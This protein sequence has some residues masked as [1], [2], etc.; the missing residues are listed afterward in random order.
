MTGTTAMICND[1]GEAIGDYVDGALQDAGARAALERHLGDCA[2]CRALAADLRRLRQ[3]A[4][5]LDVHPPPP[6]AW[7][8]IARR[9][10]SEPSPRARAW[11]GVRSWL[12][13]AAVLAL[14]AGGAVL[15]RRAQPAPA[16]GPV[17]MAPAATP[18]GVT[19]SPARAPAVS[20]ETELRLAEEHYEKAIAGLETIA[21]EGGQDLDPTTAAALQKNLRVIDDAI[22]QSRAA[23][24]DQPSNATVQ[25]SLFD[26]MKNKVALLQDTVSLINEMR[27]GNQEGAARLV[28]G[29]T[30]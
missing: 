4:A 1:Y 22:G 11:H 21:R 7:T 24:R 13:A 6:D 5:A 2:A 9:L 12:A 25:E 30:R 27:K 14:V 8:R 18:G 17:A 29:L 15:L 16:T 20:V 28:Q 26:A 23:L 10:A 19:R 3:A